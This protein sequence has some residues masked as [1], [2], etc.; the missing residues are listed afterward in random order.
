M[1]K[2]VL[3]IVTMF[4]ALGAVAQETAPAQKTFWDDPVND[5][6]LPVYLLTAFVF[7]VMVLVAFIALYLIK[8]L[9][10]LADEAEKEKAQKLGVAYAKVPTVWDKF[11]EL[12]NARV[13][14]EKEKEIELDHNY[15][16]I[17]EL[18]NHL[19][20]WWKW[21]FYGTIAFAFVYIVIYHFVDS[22][23]LQEQEYQLE[24]AQAEAQA[25]KF[26]ASQPQATI[27]EN[28]LVYIA[29]A[30][31]IG[32]GKVV[33]T[34]NACGSCHRND[35]GGNA[36]GPNLTDEYWIH[37]GDVKQVFQTIKNGVV[38]KGMPAWGKSMSPQNV[39]DV[40]FYVMSMLGSNPANAKAPQGE[41]HKPVPPTVESDSTK[42]QASLQE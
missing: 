17:R 6:M 41:L 3:S 36:I 25:R 26:Q 19:P 42:A 27:D 35:G 13:P 14:I 5:P 39:K 30:A 16:G 21:L 8:I 9:N 22:L 7:V 18:D 31:I 15:D 10:M 32:K 28:A 12:V 40:T 29:D 38:E 34:N 20:P 24:V 2:A 1:K 37:G 23:P 4:F 11:L 33:F